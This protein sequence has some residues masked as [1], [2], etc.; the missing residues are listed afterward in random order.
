MG[1]N[2]IVSTLIGKMKRSYHLGITDEHSAMHLLEVI[3]ELHL[4]SYPL[5]ILRAALHAL[6]PYPPVRSARIAFRTWQAARV[7][8]G[9]AADG[10][11]G[12]RSDQKKCKRRSSSSSRSS[13]IEKKARNRE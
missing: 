4:L 8:D 12:P 3:Y 2:T 1:F 7:R 9:G 11:A 10:G 5:R 6:P 13:P